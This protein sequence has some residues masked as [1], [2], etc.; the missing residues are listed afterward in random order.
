MILLKKKSFIF[1]Y[2]TTLSLLI[3]IALIIQSLELIETG[4]SLVN[5][6]SYFTILS[7]VFAA[8]LFLMLAF[9][10]NKSALI[11]HLKGSATLYMLITLLG[12]IV[13]FGGDKGFLLSWVNIVFHYLAPIVVLIDW[14]LFP[15]STKISF[16]SALVWTVPP[17]L[18]FIYCLVRGVI[19]S[20]YPYPFLDPE[21]IGG[22][23]NVF[24]YFIFITIF[25]I[26]GIYLLL[27]ISKSV[28]NRF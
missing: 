2:R 8:V 13:L 18:Y 24:T 10:V 4:S 20:W 19:T 14:I 21:R 6:F 22:Y 23:L 11:D 3:F 28:H 16:K 27:K 9:N 5:F 17:T 1:Y 12:F 15:I 7:N 25:G 26:L